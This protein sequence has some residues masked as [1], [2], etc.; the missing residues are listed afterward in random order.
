VT[1]AL[2]DLLARDTDT[3]GDLVVVERGRGHGEQPED[4]VVDRSAGLGHGA[5][6]WGILR[7]ICGV[8]KVRDLGGLGH[9]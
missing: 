1:A 4:T 9:E 2:V 8:N 3:S 5:L 7:V 6:L